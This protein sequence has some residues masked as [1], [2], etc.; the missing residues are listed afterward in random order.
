MQMSASS[1]LSNGSTTDEDRNGP[2]AQPCGALD[3]AAAMATILVSIGVI[4]PAMKA[5]V[6]H[7]KFSE[8]MLAASHGRLQIVDSLAIG[9]DLGGSTQS[10]S[11]AQVAQSAETY[12]SGRGIKNTSRSGLLERGI[13]G[14]QTRR[15][16]DEDQTRGGSNLSKYV[17]YYLVSKTSVVVRG[18]I[19]MGDKARYQLELVAAVRDSPSHQVV[20]WTCGDAA[21]PDGWVAHTPSGRDLPPRHLRP[22]VCNSRTA[23]R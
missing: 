17:D 6:Y 14:L 2:W 20:I 23:S 13:E 15:L 3:F 7:S 4:L 22:S 11:Q 12:L 21:V 1:V 10:T 8:A 9:T 16:G 19:D 5:P 18:A